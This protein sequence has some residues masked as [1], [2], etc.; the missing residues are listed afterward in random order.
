M[1]YEDERERV[2]ET[3][4]DVY[5]WSADPLQY[6][7]KFTAEHVYYHILI[8]F[9]RTRKTVWNAGYQRNS[10]RL[11]ELD[12]C[13]TLHSLSMDNYINSPVPDPVQHHLLFLARGCNLDFFIA[14]VLELKHQQ[15][16][17][18]ITDGGMIVEAFLRSF[19]RK[20]TSRSQ[21]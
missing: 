4:I 19:L 15:R 9:I 12:G 10:D 1:R 16:F 21:L 18:Q 14:K 7:P 11:L 8:S 17:D 3:W 2:L 5:S 6:L 20:Q 13:G